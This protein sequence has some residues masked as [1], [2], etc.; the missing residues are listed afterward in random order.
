MLA[1]YLLTALR[2]FRKSPLTSWLNVIGLAISF[3][4]CLVIFLYIHQELSFDT[5]HPHSERLFR[6]RQTINSG[7]H[8]ENSSSCPFPTMP[9]LFEDHGHMIENYVRIFDFQV[10]VKSFKLEN[11]ELF[12]ERHIYYVD[13][14]LFDMWDI[15]MIKGDPNSALDRPFTIVLSEQLAQKY[16][17]DQDPIGEVV[18]LAGH[19]HLRCEVT[20]VMGKGGPS[21]FEPQ[22]VISMSTAPRLAPFIRQNWVWN[23]CWTYIRLAEGIRPENLEAVLPDFVQ[24]HYPQFSRD[25][26]KHPLQPVEDIHL[27]SHLEF[28]MKPNSDVRYIYIFSSCGLLLLL[29]A[30]INF[31]NLTSVSL[32]ART[33]EVGIRKVVGASRAQVVTQ[34]LAEA[35]AY[36]L[37]ALVIALAILIFSQP[38]L[39]AYLQLNI[40]LRSWMQPQLIVTCIVG[41]LGIGLLAGLYPALVFSRTEVIRILRP[42]SAGSRNRHWFRKTMVVVQF[43]ISSL[44]IVFTIVSRNQLQYIQSMEKGYT[45]ENILVL[46]IATTRVPSRLEA[47]KTALKQ[48]EGISHATVMNEL[49]GVNNNNHEFNHAGMAP[50]EWKYYPALEVDEDFAS[51]FGI[52]FL[53]GRDYDATRE[54]EDSLS[55]VVNKSMAAMLGYTPGEAIGKRL[56]TMTGQ[57]RIIGVTEDFH[58]KSLHHAVGPFALDIAQ[59]PGQFNYFASHMAVRVDELSPEVLAHMEGVWKDF[60]NNKPFDYRVLS[61]EMDQLY[62]GEQRLSKLL[63][64]FSAL[65]VCVACMGLFALTWFIAR[66]KVKEI[67]IRKTLGASLANLISVATKEQ[68]L[69]VLVSFLFGFPLAFFVIQRW[70]ESFAFRVAQSP[71]P[72]LLAGLGALFIAFF[73]MIIIALRTARQDPTVVLRAEL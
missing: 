26:I 65:A 23:P 73:T 1:N 21:H 24:E 41:I 72:Y 46:D 57:E 6:L 51:T 9:A 58:F 30:C 67:A 33:R 19:D 35:G 69:T 64:I 14:T 62:G 11:G 15:P 20:G 4:A 48:H 12:N 68:L 27:H 13:S 10:P 55:L 2:S 61:E 54:K 71:M 36:T 7:G 45:T 31:I 49:L 53:E 37:I 5:S 17:G 56:N 38:L 28:E 29:I 60:V 43:A 70:L 3:A 59:R 18:F 25:M 52:Q 44:L 66:T 8:I 47:F 50:G 40:D 32:A 42:G 39:S 16:F 34:V 63:G 22:A